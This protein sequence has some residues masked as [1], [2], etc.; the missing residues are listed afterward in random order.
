MDLEWETVLLEGLVQTWMMMII[1]QKQKLQDAMK[2][3]CARLDGMTAM[4]QWLPVIQIVQPYCIRMLIQTVMD[5]LIAM[6]P[7]SRPLLRGT[8]S[9]FFCVML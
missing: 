4:I 2:L 7:S 6:C 5:G 1:A 3:E 9:P 8:S